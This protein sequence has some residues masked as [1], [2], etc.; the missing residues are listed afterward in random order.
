M[1]I[2]EQDIPKTAFRTRFTHYEF[3]VMPL[4]LT[5][6]PALFMTLMDSVLCTYL[7]KFV[8]LF[9]EDILVYS[10]TRK[11]HK[12]HLR[13]VFELLRQHSLFAKESK[14]VFFAEEIQYLG[15]II[16]AK[17]MRM[18]PE[19]VWTLRKSNLFSGG[20]RQRICKNCKYF[21]ACRVFT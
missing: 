14:C 11:E 16:F 17:G 2:R 7:G 3:L 9:L 20:Q 4:G 19:K 5:N 21:W 10:K 1:R 6:A 8:V 13:S 12:E 15:H 18:D